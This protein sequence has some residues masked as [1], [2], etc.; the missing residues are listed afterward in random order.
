MN[1]IL[2]A[3]LSLFACL[4]ASDA[5]SPKCSRN[6]GKEA[7]VCV[8]KKLGALMWQDGSVAVQG[9]F[10]QAKR[11]CGELIHG[12]FDDWRLPNKAE[13]LSITDKSR[14]EPAING[15]FK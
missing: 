11:Y 10:T 6:D 7:V 12:G 2:I 13:I 9:D 5:L 3:L 14:Y 8:D 1:K 15:A 4:N